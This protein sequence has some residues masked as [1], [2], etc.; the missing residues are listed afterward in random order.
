M[1][2]ILILLLCF[3][4]LYADVALETGTGDVHINSGAAGDFITING[5]TNAAYNGAFEVQSAVTDSFTVTATWGATDTGAWQEGSYLQCATSGLYRGIWTSCATQVGTNKT[6]II[7][8]Y[9]NT[10]A[11]TKALSIRL[12]SGATDIGT[13]TGQGLMNFTAGDRIWF[14]VESDLAQTIT[15]LVRNITID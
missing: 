8:P 13:Q 11:T 14:S 15:F 12:Y 1:K 6:V 5:A 9:V 3:S 4:F 2:R 7:R 10:T